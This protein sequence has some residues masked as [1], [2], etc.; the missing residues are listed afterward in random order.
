MALPPA[1]AAKQLFA[2]AIGP[3]ESCSCPESEQDP[4]K[5][6]EYLEVRGEVYFRCFEC[7]KP[8]DKFL[9]RPPRQQRKAKSPLTPEQGKMVSALALETLKPQ[10]TPP[11]RPAGSYLSRAR[12]SA[13]EEAERDEEVARGAAGSVSGPNNK[14]ILDDL[15]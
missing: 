15:D 9:P 11:R 6:R 3:T 13:W 12:G 4:K 5:K 10:L 14:G 7:A 1:R 2:P 8:V